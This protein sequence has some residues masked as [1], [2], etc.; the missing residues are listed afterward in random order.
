MSTKNHY[1]L[2]CAAERRAGAVSDPAVHLRRACERWLTRSNHRATDVFLAPSSFRVLLE[3]VGGSLRH[4][5]SNEGHVCFK[6]TTT[7][8]VVT[9]HRCSWLED[10]PCVALLQTDL[11]EMAVRI[12]EEVPVDWGQLKKAPSGDTVV[13]SKPDWVK[14][15]N[16]AMAILDKHQH[17]L[18]QRFWGYTTTGTVV[19][20]NCPKDRAYVIQTSFCPITL[21]SEQGTLSATPAVP[22][23]DPLD[24]VIDGKPLRVLLDIDELLRTE[25][26]GAKPHW[27]TPAQRAAV[28]AHWSA[29]LRAKVEA[30]REAERSQVL[31]DLQD[32]P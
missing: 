17:D 14:Q 25:E 1:V 7:I 13:E 8:G 4:A 10:Y 29:Q 3:Q 28:S 19:D 23:A 5:P 31:V 24:V 16:E 20:E 27:L 2:V 12:D 30:S 15:I 26:S 21:V 32:E 22:P 9:V 11:H 18:S 6:W